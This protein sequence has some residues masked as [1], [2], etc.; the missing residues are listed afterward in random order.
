M[1]L[2]GTADGIF[3]PGTVE[4]NY[5]AEQ[6]IGTGTSFRS[7]GISTGTVI[8]IGENGSYGEAVVSK[9]ISETVISIATTQFLS[10][11]PISGAG[12]TMSQ[13]PVYTLED[14]NYSKYPSIGINTYH[15]VYGVDVYEARSTVN[16][17]QKVAHAG[18]VGVHTYIDMHGNY[19]VK[20]ETLV[21]FS[22][23]TTGT[24]SYTTVGDAADDIAYPD[25]LI[26]ISSQPV[27][28]VGAAATVVQNFSVTA[29]ASPA[30]SLSY[31]WQVASSAGAA[32]TSLTNGVV[33][34]ITYTG[35][36]TATVGIGSTTSS[37][38]RPDGY[39]YRVI[40]TANDTGASVTSNAAQLDY[41]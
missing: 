4:V 5:A 34:G 16:T 6:I 31:Q 36:N 2:W 38:N 39:F 17:K 8:S 22:G 18:W 10:G 9:V 19:R 27:S 41:A 28:I 23:I 29:S 21:A 20:S 35:T 40:V 3:S 13:K 7:S 12:Y 1:A 33:Y 30:A 32:Y 25:T 15:S 26:T 24:P 37:T 11:L 14:S